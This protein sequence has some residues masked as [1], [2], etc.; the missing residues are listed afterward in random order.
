M[1]KGGGGVKEMERR[2]MGDM[3]HEF[4]IVK[5]L[6][7]TDL[8]MKGIKQVYL[9][10]YFLASYHNY[11]RNLSSQPSFSTEAEKRLRKRTGRF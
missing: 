8:N 1:G 7:C 5:R 2:G 10:Q 4:E 9:Y 11:Q 6:Y 3:A